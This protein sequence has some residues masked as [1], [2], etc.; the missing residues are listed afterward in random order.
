MYVL[1]GFIDMHGHIGGK[2]QG[3]PAEYVF[4]LWMAHGI[5][6]VREPGCG[7]G[8]DWTL[9]ERER[10]A[11]NEITAP[12]IVPYIFFGIGARRPITT[13]EQARKWVDAVG[14]EAAPT[15]S[16]SS[17]T[18]PD[19]MQARASTRRRSR[20]CAPPATSRRWTWRGSTS[21]TR[22]AGA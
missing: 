13:P 11:A 19:I 8:V 7:N 12:R 5:T 10:S 9:H 21:S 4:K 17:A 14:G 2:E 22:R 1:P 3:T 20:A 16:S 6:T 18:R 15:A